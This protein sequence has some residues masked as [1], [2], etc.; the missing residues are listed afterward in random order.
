MFGKFCAADCVGIGVG[1]GVSLALSGGADRDAELS[2]IPP[3]KINAKIPH[4]AQ[5]T[6]LEFC[7]GSSTVGGGGG[8]PS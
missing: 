7:T 2:A 5:R 4:S 3:N 1:D 6:V 8:A